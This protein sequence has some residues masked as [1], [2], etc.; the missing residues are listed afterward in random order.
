MSLVNKYGSPKEK[1]A[2]TLDSTINAAVEFLYQKNRDNKEIAFQE[3]QIDNT[4][5]NAQIQNLVAQYGSQI[6]VPPEAYE[7]DTALAGVLQEGKRLAEVQK[8]ALRATTQG[9]GS[10]S[11]FAENALAFGGVE[12]TA[13]D[14]S[15]QTLELDQSPLGLNDSDLEVVDQWIMGNSYLNGASNKEYITSEE[16]REFERLGLL[17]AGLVDEDTWDKDIHGADIQKNWDDYRVFIQSN[18]NFHTSESYES[19]ITQNLQKHKANLELLYLNPEYK[20]AS[21]RIAVFDNTVA[22][23]LTDADGDYSVNGLKYESFDAFQDAHPVLAAVSVMGI[24]QLASQWQDIDVKL[25]EE[26]S[27]NKYSLSYHSA[28]VQ[29]VNDF[30]KVEGMKAEY[31][32]SPMNAMQEGDIAVGLMDAMHDI[33]LQ[34]DPL[35]LSLQQR[36]L[37]PND[38][39]VKNQ[40]DIEREYMKALSPI[41]VNMR[42]HESG[43]WSVDPTTGDPGP[44]EDMMDEMFDSYFYEILSKVGV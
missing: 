25:R 9:K 35:A 26:S 43:L 6:Y 8:S 18:R 36:Y 1:L 7:D 15:I 17:E 2:N 23:M 28:Y 12:I 20:P 3:R 39:S 41:I 5:R 33:Q 10:L 32:F 38:S 21:D 27:K 4:R 16:I 31:D 42:T 30:N 11:D 22:T 40:A 13:N 14:G 19:L 44:N 29:I 37:D 34:L 24:D